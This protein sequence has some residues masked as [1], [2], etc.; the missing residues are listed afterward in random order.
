MVSCKWVNF[1][2]LEL[3][4]FR[5]VMTIFLAHCEDCWALSTL[6]ALNWWEHFKKWHICIKL[7]HRV[8]IKL[9][10]SQIKDKFSVVI[11]KA[12]NYQW[13]IH[14]SETA[15]LKEENVWD[16][17][18]NNNN[19]NNKEHHKP[20]TKQRNKKK[21]IF[22]LKE[23][24]NFEKGSSLCPRFP[25]FSRRIFTCWKRWT[26]PAFYYL[27]YKLSNKH[28]EK[29]YNIIFSDSTKPQSILSWIQNEI[30]FIL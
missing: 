25:K 26:F 17:F 4:K 15:R 6:P 5:A 29:T 1:L 20:V 9:Y 10:H 30:L 19:N 13:W 23:I 24:K 8:S 12:E 2:I 11:L 16:C 7:K 3:L 18:F 14:K 27:E 28:I 22:F 21:K